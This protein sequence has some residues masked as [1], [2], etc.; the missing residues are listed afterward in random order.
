MFD[1]L[2]HKDLTEEEGLALMLKGIEEVRS[3]MC[4]TLVCKAIVVLRDHQPALTG[5]MA[6]EDLRL[7]CHVRRNTCLWIV[8]CLHYKDDA[9]L[10]VKKR[11]VV[12]P[13]SY[14]IKIIDANGTRTVKTISD[15]D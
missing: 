4:G 10:Q 12:A 8:E 14:C 7:F 9:C 3:C 15:S 1:R 6:P 13:P 5:R 2:W 11:L